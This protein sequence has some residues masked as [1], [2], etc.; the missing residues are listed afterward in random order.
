MLPLLVDYQ[1]CRIYFEFSTNKLS[2]STTFEKSIV[3]NGQLVLAGLDLGHSW[4]VTIQKKSG[5]N[6]SVFFF[7]KKTFFNNKEQN[8]SN[9]S[10]GVIGPT[11]LLAKQLRANAF[12]F[13]FESLWSFLFLKIFDFS[14]NNGLIN[15]SSI[16]FL[17]CS[18]S[19]LV[20]A[21][22]DCFFLLLI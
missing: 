8:I 3:P 4:T 10:S 6:Q 7:I 14:I 20:S 1:K 2:I 17:I 19:S 11:N 12:N 18:T 15:F 16:F 5:C 21:K 9:Q 13:L 22:N